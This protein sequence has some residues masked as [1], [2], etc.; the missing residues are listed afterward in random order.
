MSD[1]LSNE[2]YGLS[3]ERANPTMQQVGCLGAVEMM[4]S[5][6]EAAGGE[7]KT[8][9]IAVLTG[10]PADEARVK[11]AAANGSVRAALGALAPCP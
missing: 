3:N 10:L 5:I 8:A 11:I 2:L 6:L 7:T 1:A 4:W 9:I